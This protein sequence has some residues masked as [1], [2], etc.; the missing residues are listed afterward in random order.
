MQ[1]NTHSRFETRRFVGW[2]VLLVGQFCWLVSFAVRSVLLLGQF[3]WLVRLG[4]SLLWK[5]GPARWGNL[6]QVP[7]HHG[8]DQQTRIV[9]LGYNTITLAVTV[10]L[11]TA[12]SLTDGG[13]A[14]GFDVD[15]VSENA[16]R[17]PVGKIG[18]IG[19]RCADDEPWPPGLFRGYLQADGT[20]DSSPFRSGWYFTG[21]MGHMDEDGYIWFEVS[22]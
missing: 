19:I 8:Y 12:A 6:Y 20:V 15:I 17:E 10:T 5:Q 16:E 4:T 11:F 18:H 7:A 22:S 3:C 13:T 9:C 1:L 14:S 2:S 21:D